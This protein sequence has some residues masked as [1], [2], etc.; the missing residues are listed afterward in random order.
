LRFTP[1]SLG[2]SDLDGN[3]LVNEGLKA[4]DRVV[5]YS[6]KALNTRSRIHVLDKLPGVEP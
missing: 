2:V 4:G 3:V 1:V 6:V 5:I